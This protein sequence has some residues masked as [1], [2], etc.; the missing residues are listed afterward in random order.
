MI[1]VMCV[2]LLKYQDD[3]NDDGYHVSYM[4]LLCAL[5]ARYPI[6]NAIKKLLYIDL[7][8]NSTE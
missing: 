1:N 2:R 3:P 5:S 8:A 4:C 7:Y 6:R